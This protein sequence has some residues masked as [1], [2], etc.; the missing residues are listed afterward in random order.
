VK[1]NVSDVFEQGDVT[2]EGGDEDD[3]GDDVIEAR[4]KPNDEMFSSWIRG[5]P[6]FVRAK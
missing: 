6:C 2:D 1:G 5:S 4:N 3:E